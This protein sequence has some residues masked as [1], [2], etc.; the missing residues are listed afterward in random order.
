MKNDVY[1][2]TTQV[3]N[4]EGTEL[5]F[6][7]YNSKRELLGYIIVSNLGIASW[8]IINLHYENILKEI[9]SEIVGM[10]ETRMLHGETKYIDKNRW[11]NACLFVVSRGL[12]LNISPGKEQEDKKIYENEK[13]NYTKKYR[14][15]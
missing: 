11:Y 15:I 2:K 10:E 9:L 14:G 8:S 4:K 5:N 6:D 13:R 3:F 12:V 1:I 7:F